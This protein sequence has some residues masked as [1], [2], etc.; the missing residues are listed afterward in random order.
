MKMWSHYYRA[1]LMPLFVL[2][3]KMVRIVFSQRLVKCCEKTCFLCMEITQ[4]KTSLCIRPSTQSDHHLCYS[5]SGK[6]NEFTGLD[7]KKN[8]A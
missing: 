7:K 5:I 1:P 8:P 6:D 3:G 4:V 2:S